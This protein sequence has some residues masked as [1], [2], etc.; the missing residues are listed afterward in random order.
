[1]FLD[2][3]KNTPDFIPQYHDYEVIPNEPLPERPKWKTIYIS[4]GKKDK[5]NKVDIVGFLHKT[6]GLRPD[7]IG[8]ITVMDYSSFVA[9]SSDIAEEVVPELRDK[10]IKG[11]KQ[12]IGFAR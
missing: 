2:P 1:M 3:S 8:L 4:A 11:K 6:G 9:I 5:V 7:E 12:K 10:K